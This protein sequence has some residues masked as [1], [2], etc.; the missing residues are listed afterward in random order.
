MTVT[1]LNDAIILVREMIK[2]RWEPMGIVSP[3]APGMYEQQFLDTMGKYSEFII[4]TL[5]WANPKSEMTRQL[6]AE[7]KRITPKDKLPGHIFNMSFT[8]EALMICA[9]AHKRAA[10]TQGAALADA[11][12]A[13]KIDKRIM[14]GGPIEFDAKGQCNTHRVGRVAEPQG[15]ADHRAAGRRRRGQAGLSDAGLDQ[16]RLKASCRRST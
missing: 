4:T 16:A 7:F 13:T 15:R 3:G 9:D 8:F 10:S 1:R 11:L 12:R 14:I 6:A 2:Q 5:P